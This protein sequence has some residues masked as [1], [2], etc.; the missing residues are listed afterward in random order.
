MQFEHGL[1]FVFVLG[2]VVVIRPTDVSVRVFAVHVRRLQIRLPLLVG[3]SA[4]RHAL[5]ELIDRI[6][7]FR[8][9]VMGA[10]RKRPVDRV[11][12]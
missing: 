2:Q 4:A 1:L 8:G 11:V 10:E 7:V 12:L 6:E 3:N 9:G 5:R